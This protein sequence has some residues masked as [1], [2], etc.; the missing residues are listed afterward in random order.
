MFYGRKEQIELTGLWRRSVP[1]LVVFRGRRHIGK[2]TLK[3][4]LIKETLDFAHTSYGF[5]GRKGFSTTTLPYFCPSFKSSVKITEQP[6]LFAAA[7]IR[8]S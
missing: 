5:R 2:P 8:A 6:A 1:S 7:I 3:P 4:T